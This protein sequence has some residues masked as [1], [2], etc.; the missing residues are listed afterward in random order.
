[1]PRKLLEASA[2]SGLI[3]VMSSWQPCTCQKGSY[4]IL[5]QLQLLSGPQGQPYVECFIL[6][7]VPLLAAVAGG[8]LHMAATATTNCPMPPLHL[9]FPQLVA[10][11]APQAAE[12]PCTQPITCCQSAAHRAACEAACGK[13][14]C[15]G[16]ARWWIMVA[17]A[18]ELFPSPM[19]GQLGG[20]C[21]AGRGVLLPSSLVLSYGFYS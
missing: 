8:G 9:T 19:S 2:D 13:A 11:V 18:W 3:G 12:K 7:G 16:S 17:A 4:C 15:H 20:I 10:C 14:V 6:R 1:M 21:V 5:Y